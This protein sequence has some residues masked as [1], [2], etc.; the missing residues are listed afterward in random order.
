M[1][2]AE[3]LF[4]WLA[5]SALTMSLRVPL[6]PQGSFRL[7]LAVETEMSP[8]SVQVVSLGEQQKYATLDLL[9]TMDGAAMRMLSPGAQRDEDA[10]ISVPLLIAVADSAF[11]VPMHLAVTV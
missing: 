8:G 9:A 11:H 10:A 2:C 4:L 1:L 6:Q 5:G 3:L 7:P